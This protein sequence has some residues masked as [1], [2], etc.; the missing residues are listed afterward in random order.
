MLFGCLLCFANEWVIDF[1]CPLAQKIHQAKIYCPLN[2]NRNFNRTS[3]FCQPPDFTFLP[4]SLNRRL[5]ACLSASIYIVTLIRV[6][7]T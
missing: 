2:E 4:E 1:T 5:C 6:A 7:E 3:S